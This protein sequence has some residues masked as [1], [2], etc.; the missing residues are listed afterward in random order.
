MSTTTAKLA[1]S[2]LHF[3]I[4]S[5][6][7]GQRIGLWTQGCSIGCKGC[8]SFYTWAS[9]PAD[10]PIDEII[11]RLDPWLGEADGLTISGGEPFDQPEAM[12]GF[13]TAI[14]PRMTGDILLFTGYA[15]SDI[16]NAARTALENLDALICGPFVEQRA[17]ELPLRGSDNQEF[18]LFT[19]LGR[20]RYG[21]L[22]TGSS[23]GSRIDLIGTDG[24]LW[25]AGIPKPGDLDRLDFILAARGLSLVTSIGRLGARR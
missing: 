8:M 10:T 6:G 5:L 12:L 15:F 3:P 7:Y 24:E 1:L 21:D 23:T 19:N 11:T 2:R 18:L 13:L 25:F 22:K 16:P 20:D 9:G 14:R 4:T 17:S